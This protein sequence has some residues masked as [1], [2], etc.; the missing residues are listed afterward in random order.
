MIESF[1]AKMIKVGD[2]TVRLPGGR[3][4]TLGDGTGVPVVL[5]MN[6]RG[7]RRL[8]ANPGLGLGEG[9]MDGDIVLETGTMWDLLEIV[10]RGGSRGPKGRG[11]WFK[12]VRRSLKRRWQ[13]A[14]DR[15]AARRNVSHHYDISN[16]L[17]R[18]FLDEDMQYSCAY[19]ARPDMTLEEAQL[20]KKRHLGA[21]MDLRPGHRVLEIGSGWGGLA[22]TLA[23]E[24]GADVTGVTLSTEQLSG[25]RAGAGRGSPG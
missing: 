9:Y 18:R 8:V 1:L 5:R 2:L 15:I 17:Y 23:D 22:L 3:V 11:T 20:A 24:F 13:Q 14:N 10:G 7:V 6:G 21:K 4:M 19:F 25:A 16:Q 12:R